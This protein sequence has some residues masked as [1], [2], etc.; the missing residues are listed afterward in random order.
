MTLEDGSVTTI[1]APQS[2]S[3]NTPVSASIATSTVLQGDAPQHITT[4]STP[5]SSSYS[6]STSN[7]VMS[8]RVTSVPQSSSYPIPTTSNAAMSTR[9]TSVPDSSSYPI[10]TQQSSTPT[11][12]NTV[13]Y[14]T[15][16]AGLVVSGS[17]KQ[18]VIPKKTTAPI[19]TIGGVAF[20][21]SGLELVAGTLTL[22][23]GQAITVSE[24]N[25]SLAPSATALILGTS[26]IA[27]EPLA[28]MTLP[29]SHLPAVT[30]DGLIATANSQS[31]YII[32]GQTLI[33]G[34]PAITVSG[35]RISLAP[36]A[37]AIVIGTSA[38]PFKPS[39]GVSALPE[40]ITVEGLTVTANAQ[41]ELTT[42]G[43]KTLEPGGPAITISGTPVLLASGGSAVIIGT[44]TEAISA[45]SSPGLAGIIISGLVSMAP[46]PSPTN[47]LGVPFKGSGGRLEL[48]AW[49]AVEAFGVLS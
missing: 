39:L 46:A 41:S 26:T 6:S 9:G 5:A 2:A 14:F 45:P 17:T 25:I 23:P 33:P 4:T 36:S 12:S 43:T 20:T 16:S 10:R 30:L 48:P 28:G 34:G 37:A 7:A 24:K 13:L 27:L 19:D 49:G 44:L 22:A 11:A 42:I 31:D 32:G 35:T 38:I 40:V 8:K 3:A 29:P 18:V 1:T 47:S 21:P 15:S